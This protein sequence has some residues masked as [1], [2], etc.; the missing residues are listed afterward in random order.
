MGEVN[1]IT[2]LAVVTVFTIFSALVIGT[3]SE[4]SPIPTFREPEG[5]GFFAALDALLSILKVIWGVIVFIGKAMT[6]DI[7]GAP[8]FVRLVIGTLTVGGVSWAL[9]SMIRGR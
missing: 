2:I 1:P 3:T 8:W 7:P 4:E 9:A 6:L 5:S